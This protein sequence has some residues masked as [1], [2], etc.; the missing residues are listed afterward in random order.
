MHGVKFSEANFKI[1]VFFR[2]GVETNECVYMLSECGTG[3]QSQSPLTPK[4]EF[5]L[6]AAYWFKSAHQTELSGQLL[7]ATKQRRFPGEA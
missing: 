6:L 2:S 1:Y 7:L 3:P 4:E 5:S